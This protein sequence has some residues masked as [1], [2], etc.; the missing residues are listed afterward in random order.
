MHLLLR[1]GSY[2]FNGTDCILYLLLLLNFS[3]S[4]FIYLFM[5]VHVCMW[6]YAWHG[7]H[8]KILQE[9]SLFPPIPCGF[10]KCHHLQSHRAGHR[11]H[12]S[13]FHGSKRKRNSKRN[14]ILAKQQLSKAKT[15]VI[16]WELGTRSYSGGDLAQDHYWSLM[17]ALICPW[18]REFTTE[19][20]F[21]R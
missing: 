21:C 8:V 16:L 19:N 13:S 15:S 6:T 9:Q 17:E 2:C 12:N 14:K 4:P 1:M 3:I 18:A 11:V 7:A 10:L 5:Y 20:L